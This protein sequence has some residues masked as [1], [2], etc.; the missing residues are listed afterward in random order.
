M[1]ACMYADWKAV[2]MDDITTE[3]WWI[4]KLIFSGTD[5]KLRKELLEL[6]D[7][8]EEEL[9]NKERSYENAQFNISTM[10]SEQAV[11]KVLKKEF[12][13]NCG[14]CL[15]RK[16]KAR[17][18]KKKDKLRCE[19]KKGGCGGKG[20]VHTAYLCPLEREKRQRGRSS[21]RNRD[22]SPRRRDRSCNKTESEGEGDSSPPPYDDYE[23]EGNHK[24]RT[25][26]TST[27]RAR[28]TKAQKGNIGQHTCSKIHDSDETPLLSCDISKKTRNSY[29]S[30]RH[31]CLP[32]SGMTM[33]LI[34]KNL[35]SRHRFKYDRNAKVA[36]KDAS[37][38]N[39]SV[40]MI[41]S[42]G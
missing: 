13:G 37:G 4:M 20:H 26:R 40:S 33:P 22:K 16:H 11:R 1:K 32:D 7:P 30:F 6:S 19:K 38:D 35:V 36:A 23:E 29:L 12:D 24:V 25:A 42:K 3:K 5:D 14:A 31:K 27:H 21:S 17:E 39:M 15:G 9:V 28:M 2:G 34:S 18:C 41:N 8:N 10:E